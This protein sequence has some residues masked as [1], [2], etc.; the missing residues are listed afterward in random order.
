MTEQ[1]AIA[2]TIEQWMPLAESGEDKPN[3]KGVLYSCYLCQYAKEKSGL[4]FE[5]SICPYCPY[6]KKYGLCYKTREPFDLWKR[7]GGK[8]QK[9]EYAKDFSLDLDEIFRKS[10]YKLIPFSHRPYGKLY[11][12]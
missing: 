3:L 6:Y 9:C 12:Y 5:P 2:K 10:F 1:E 7:E 11:A 4:C 8:H